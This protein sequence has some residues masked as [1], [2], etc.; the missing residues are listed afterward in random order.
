MALTETQQERISFHLDI[1]N[2]YNLLSVTLN[3]R[4]LDYSPEKEK[5]IV[6]NL[7]TADTDEILT[8]MGESLCTKDSVLGRVEIA[9][10]K[11]SPD[12]VDDS[13]LVKKAGNVELRSDEYRARKRVYQE[14]VKELKRITGYADLG[15]DRAS[16]SF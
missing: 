7:S 12:N 14:K 11:L 6:G 9:Y 16:L 1:Y 5:S 2:D 15:N 3:V 8:H 13:L 10:R 4:Q